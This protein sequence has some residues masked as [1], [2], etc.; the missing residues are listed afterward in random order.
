[1]TNVIELGEFRLS[2]QREHS[3]PK[4]GE[5]RHMRLQLDDRGDIVRCSDC[6]AQISAYWALTM[7]AEEFSRWRERLEAQDKRL[8]EE[9]GK[10]LHLIAARRVEKLWRGHKM[11]PLCPHCNRGVLL[12]DCFGNAAISREIEL[13]RRT[14][15]KLQT[16]GKK[17]P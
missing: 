6:G 12:E 7:L 4:T 14:A 5:C 1:M 13:R 3:L 16:E 11:A 8:R 9:Q 2:R 10:A 15:E 17:T